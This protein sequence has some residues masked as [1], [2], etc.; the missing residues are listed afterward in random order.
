MQ[1]KPET[2]IKLDKFKPRDYQKP[3]CNAFENKGYKKILAIWPRRAGKDLVAWNLMLREALRKVG[4][5]FYCL[6]THRQS[7]LVI[8]DTITNEGMG[9]KDYIPKELIAHINN[10]EMS[11]RLI[12]NSQIKLIGSDT[13]DTSLVGTNPRM[14]VFSEYALSNENAY[15][16]GARPI[17]NAN[18]GKVIIISTPRGRNALWELYNIASNSDD[19]FCQKLTLSETQHISPEEIQAE[20]ESGEIS[21]DLAAQEY[22]TSFALGVEG[23]YY[24]K[25]IDK[26]RLNNQIC[27]VPYEPQFRVNTAW[28]IGLNDKT[29][30]VFFQVVGQIVRIIDYYEGNDYGLEHYVKMLQEKDYIY[31]KHIAPHDVRVREWGNAGVTRLEKARQLGIEFVVAP[32]VPVSDGI[33]SVRTLFP[34]LWIDEKNCKPL[35][36]ALE[37]YRREYDSKNKTYK[38]RPLHDFASDAADAMRYLALALPRIRDDSS[39]DDIERRYQEAMYGNQSKMP[40]IFRDDI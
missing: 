35:I 24:T 36:K 39:A 13:Y 27:T 20:I 15:K 4:S 37:S 26:L 1:F 11:I 7:R 12:N 10:T 8:W 19:W 25:Y 40:P 18:D 6:P 30:V 31:G 9:F 33:E 23:S 21:A 2:K 17:L 34:R 28:D 22:Y 32:R 29:V 16:L 14:I 38:D 3:I 5:Y